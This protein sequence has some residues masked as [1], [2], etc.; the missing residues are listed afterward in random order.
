MILEL[1]CYPTYNWL[2]LLQV[3]RIGNRNIYEEVFDYYYQIYLLHV[4]YHEDETPVKPCENLG[5]FVL[6][7]VDI[8]R[9]TIS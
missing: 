7:E 9:N 6:Y 4:S 5:H 1:S 3:C 2:R 8:A